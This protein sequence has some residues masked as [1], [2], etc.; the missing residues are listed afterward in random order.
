MR[1]SPNVSNQPTYELLIHLLDDNEEQLREA[2]ITTL[3]NR[4]SDT[5]GYLSDLHSQGRRDAVIAWRRWYIELFN[6]PPT[7]P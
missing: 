6:P 7:K 5:F 4:H 1:C 3:L 2:A